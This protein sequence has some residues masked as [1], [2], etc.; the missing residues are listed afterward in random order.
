MTTPY[1][2]GKSVENFKSSDG[3]Y[4]F[5]LRRT[6]DGDLYLLKAKLNDP[7]QE[8]EL[9]GTAM[10]V[11][12][13]DYDIPGDDWFD[14]R[15]EDHTLQ[16]TREE[17]KYEQWKW[18]DTLRSYYIDSDGNFVLV[19][20]EDVLLSQIDDIQI[21]VGHQQSFTIVG[22]NYNINLYNHLI[23]L[24]WNGVSEVNVTINGDIGSTHPSKPALL[25]DKQFINGL[26]IINNGNII[27]CN[28]NLEYNPTANRYNG[29][30]I[31]VET[32][33]DS[34]ENN[35]LL[36]AG[37]FNGEYANVFRGYSFVDTFEG[38]GGTWVGYDD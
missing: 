38:S 16:F 5:A 36:K 29:V 22:E 8:Y 13:A 7:N 4:L 19:T 17:V 34:F 10:P 32:A 28:G 23:E 30:A 2:L 37:V 6:E 3:T 14:G 18:E 12:F 35:G 27:G 33:V 26:N 20:G 25:I 24:G 1:V 31:I 21:P 9:F 15:N 11:E